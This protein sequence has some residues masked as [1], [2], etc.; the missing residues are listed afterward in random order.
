VEVADTVGAGDSFM[1]GLIDGLWTAGLLGAER[2]EALHAI[3]E[4]T[5]TG[6]LERCVR[7]AAITVSRPGAN[8]PTAEELDESPDR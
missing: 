3:D 4:A 2:R 5:L 8:P 1:G 6:V 7:I